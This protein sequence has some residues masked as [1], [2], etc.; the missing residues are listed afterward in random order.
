[1][2]LY[3]EINLLS[4][5]LLV[6]I[7]FHAVKE[8]MSYPL[9]SLFVTS[10]SFIILF[11]L[12]DL[13]WYYS[14]TKLV[15]F[16]IPII[17]VI[18]ILNFTSSGM[19]AYAWFLYSE[20]VQNQNILKRKR[21]ILLTSL[22]L[23]ILIIATLIPSLMFS[24]TKEGGYE[25]GP[26][27]F[28]EFVI[29]CFYL[30]S[31]SLKAL[32]SSGKR[33]NFA[34][35]NEFLSLAS[36]ALAPAITTILQVFIT[37]TPLTS[38]GMCIAAILVFQRQQALLVSIDPLTGLNNRYEM[39]RFLLNKMNHVDSDK[40]L[41]LLVADVDYF[42]KINDKYGHLEGDYALSL[43]AEALKN[44]ATKHRC[45]VS[46]Y[47][48][49]EFVIIF[50]RRIKDISIQ[51]FCNSINENISKLVEKANLKY[52]LKLS[53]G[54]ALYNSN[55]QSLLDFLDKADLSLYEVKRNR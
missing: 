23:L 49:D 50:E 1:M 16:P 22:P 25:R 13:L 48:G 54:Y 35:K 29:P 36:F 17:Y 10:L 18:D 3:S 40:A 8:N 53:I 26:L 14:V 32:I 55:M 44:V 27:F 46:R 51:E 20:K 52:S 12:T 7:L 19:A 31:T 47:G 41:Y 21:F 11:I 9:K 39:T 33:K 28:L 2:L 37:G 38:I 6:P 34:Y 4:I 45:F 24:I 30:V 15:R 43:V 42:K 5:C